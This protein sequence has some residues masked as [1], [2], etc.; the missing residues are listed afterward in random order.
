VSPA[1][2]ALQA[3]L[4]VALVV[5]AVR[6]ERDRRREERSAIRRVP[7]ER[8]RGAAAA[9]GS[10]SPT[11]GIRLR[12][13]GDSAESGPGR[14][15]LADVELGQFTLRE[16]ARLLLLR[17]S[18]QDA[19]IGQG[20]LRND[21]EADPSRWWVVPTRSPAGLMVEARGSEHP[22][23]L[24]EG[25]VRAEPSVS[26]PVPLGEPSPS[27]GQQRWTGR[28]ITIALGTLLLVVGAL[29][30]VR[31]DLPM[32]S[33]QDATGPGVSMAGRFL[34]GLIANPG[35]YSS[36]V[37]GS[38]SSQASLEAVALL[39]QKQAM[40]R[41]EAVLLVGAGLLLATRGSRSS[42]TPTPEGQAA[43]QS[44]VANDLVPFIFVAALLFG[45]LSFFELA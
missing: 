11:R 20:A 19:R 14:L 43:R 40:D 4:L 42:G 27:T 15:R 44:S 3:L 9:D 2:W 38:S 22:R 17:G 28:R 1:F 24:G 25:R 23:P 13:V 12:W 32:Q 34:P 16:R 8:R 41:W 31:T 39:Q 21:L 6:V 35:K 36:A 33:I 29:G 7:V 26:E 5:T 10:A 45:A 30:V 37:N 18:V